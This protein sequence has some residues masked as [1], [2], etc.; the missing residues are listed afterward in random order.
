[1]RTQVSEG[2]R[3]LHV[4]LPT[5]RLQRPVIASIGVWGTSRQVRVTPRDWTNV[6]YFLSCNSSAVKPLE[7]ATPCCSLKNVVRTQAAVGCFS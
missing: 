1:M 2:Q 4:L 5:R 6:S 3:A 7:M